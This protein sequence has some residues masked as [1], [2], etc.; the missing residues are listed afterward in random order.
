MAEAIPANDFPMGGDQPWDPGYGGGHVEPGGF[1]PDGMGGE[2]WDSSLIGAP[3]G[4]GF[5]DSMDLWEPGSFQSMD[6]GGALMSPMSVV[7]M[8]EG[9]MGEEG[10]AMGTAPIMEEEDNAICPKCNLGPRNFGSAQR[11][12]Y[13]C[14]KCDQDEHDQEVPDLEKAKIP[15]N[16]FVWNAEVTVGDDPVP[17]KVTICNTCKLDVQK[18]GSLNW[19][20]KDQQ[21]SQNV[22][23]TPQTP[24]NATSNKQS[25]PKTGGTRVESESF[26]V[27]SMNTADPGC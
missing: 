26:L 22:S 21:V 18:A 17:Y 4:A 14:V 24:Q 2:P 27:I 1:Q 7:A 13:I 11:N 10:V 20:A 3:S 9:G 15:N 23:A 8:S 12:Q 16:Q 6:A 19:K 5:D 25:P